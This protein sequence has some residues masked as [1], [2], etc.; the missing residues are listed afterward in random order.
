[1]QLKFNDIHGCGVMP[2]QSPAYPQD[3]VCPEAHTIIVTVEGDATAVKEVLSYTPFEYVSNVFQVWVADLKGHSLAPET[4]GYKE[5]AITIPVRYGD[6]RGGY[7]PWMFCTNVEAVLVGREILGIAKQ[8]AEIDFISTDVAAAGIVRR[9]GVDLIKV[10]YVFEEAA[11]PEADRISEIQAINVNRMM[12]RVFPKATEYN[13]ADFKQVIYRD[14]ARAVGKLAA[15]RGAVEFGESERNPIALL[16]I[17]RV[18]GATYTVSRYGG[19]L[20]AEK[21]IVL[22]QS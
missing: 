11:H 1:M 16:G 4:S 8:F 13:S 17:R 15:S 20:V 7:S 5:A 10:G 14:S 2:E 9:D 3:W 22:A 6:Y 18:L 19:G 12:Y 21:R